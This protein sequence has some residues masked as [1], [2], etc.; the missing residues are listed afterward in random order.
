MAN[1]SPVERIAMREALEL[2]NQA[3]EEK[4]VTRLDIIQLIRDKTRPDSEAKPNRTDQNRTEPHKT[5]GIIGC[6]Y[7]NG[8]GH[9]NG[10]KVCPTCKGAGKNII[11]NMHNKC[12][13]CGGLGHT[14]GGKVCVTCQGVGYVRPQK[15]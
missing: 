11:S 14:D 15:R 13:Y 6:A 7:C 12:A 4:F 5:P 1:F 2:L 3:I 9:V 8:L 10:G